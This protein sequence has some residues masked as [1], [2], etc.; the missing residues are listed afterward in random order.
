V[1]LEEHVQGLRSKAEVPFVLDYEPRLPY[2]LARLARDVI[3]AGDAGQAEAVHRALNARQSRR[4][5]L[6]V[7]VVAELAAG[8]DHA[9]QLTQ[10]ALGIPYRAEDERRDAGVERSAVY[11][12]RFRNPVDDPYRSGSVPR[13]VFCDASEIGPS[14]R[15]NTG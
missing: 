9:E 10:G 4:P 14:S 12:Q 15:A 6:N 8:S 5:R 3:A 11:F 13:S 2:E 1:R 7:L